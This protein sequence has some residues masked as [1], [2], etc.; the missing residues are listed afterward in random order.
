MRSPVPFTLIYFAAVTITA[1]PGNV[2]AADDARWMNLFNGKSLQGWV[3]KCRP[4]DKQKTGYWKVVNGTITAE[5]PHGSN[6]NYIW[7]LTREEFGDF[8]LKLKVQTYSKSTGNSGIQV[9]SR[10]DDEAHYLD[11]P[12]V[13]INPPGPWRNGFIYDE[14][15]GAQIWLWPNV[16]KPANAKPSHAPKGWKWFDADKEDVWNEVNIRCRGMK[17]RSVINGMT[18]ADYDGGGRLDDAVHRK[19]N[20]GLKGNIGLQIHPGGEMV[21]RFRDILV[22][23]ME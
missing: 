18:I 5:T 8:E 14:T 9:R 22:R 20:V 2:T 12:Q 11:G 17:I 1:F 6:H 3:V 21:I 10:Y 23:S 15:R 19:R 7:L 4:E 16:G 13:D